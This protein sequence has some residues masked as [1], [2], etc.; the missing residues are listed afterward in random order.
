MVLP[1]VEPGMVR[2]YLVRPGSC[3]ATTRVSVDTPDCTFA[4]RALLR[5]QPGDLAGLEDSRI[6]EQWA[7]RKPSL[8]L[9]RLANYSDETSLA[10]AVQA[11]IRE[12]GRKTAASAPA[13]A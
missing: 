7:R 5:P 2:L 13:P 3:L 8:P 1:A 9:I 4:V 10:H 6:A 12:T 11:K